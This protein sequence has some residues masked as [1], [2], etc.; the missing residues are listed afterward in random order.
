MGAPTDEAAAESAQSSGERARTISR[1]KIG[2]ALPMMTKGT[3]A[4]LYL[5]YAWFLLW[6]WRSVGWWEGSSE[7]PYS[8]PVRQLGRA[9]AGAL[10]RDC[11][12]RRGGRR[13][14]EG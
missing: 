1:P 5:W 7:P 8:G 11:G 2:E 6:G 10:R 14:E 3:A 12:D 13:G 4:A 9:V